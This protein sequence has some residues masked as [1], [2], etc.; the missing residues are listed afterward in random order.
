MI[1]GELTNLRAVERSDSGSLH[2]WFN[3]P[4]LMRFWG[5]PDSTISLAEIQRRIEEWIHEEGRLGRPVCL[6][7]ETLEGETLGVVILSQYEP[8]TASI[9]LS[10]MVGSV[11]RW[12]E[13][14]GSDILTSVVEAGFAQ[15][16]LHRISLRVEE[17]N[18][19]AIRLYERCGFQRDGILRDASFFDGEY[20]DQ[21]L[22]S[23]LS[24]DR[25]IDHEAIQS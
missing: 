17:F 1:R 14:F 9:E 5:A 13:G 18:V 3:D 7:A 24:T 2:S 11:D 19:R 6:I 15:W 21:F 12:G 10:M 16:R 8:V 4:E 22:Y 23:L 20:R 25:T